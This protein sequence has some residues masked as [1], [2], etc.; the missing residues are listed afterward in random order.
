VDK[1]IVLDNAG[2]SLPMHSPSEVAGA[3]L[4]DWSLVAV[5]ATVIFLG[6]T[7]YYGVCLYPGLGGE[8]NSGD[9]AK[10]QVLGVAPIMMHGPGYPLILMIASGLRALELPI[11]GWWLIT[12]TISAVPGAI[13]NAVAFL[14]IHRLT[15]HF[16]AAIAAA[17]LLGSAS[18]MA[19]QAT[20]AEVYA[21]HI[22]FVLGIIYLLLRFLEARRIEF[23]LAAA[24]VYAFSFGNHLMM[25]MMLPLF[26][27]LTFLH[28]RLILRSDVIITVL[29]FIVLGASQYLYLAYVAWSPHTAWSEY[30]PLQPTAV[31][32]IRYIL[33]FHFSNLYGSGLSSPLTTQALLKTIGNAHPWISG[34]LVAIGLTTLALGWRTRD[35]QWC[36]IALVYGVALCFAPFMLWY[37]APDIQAFH[38]PVLAP[39]LLASIA[40]VMRELHHRPAFWRNGMVVALLITGLFRSGETAVRLSD[41]ES[42]F[43]ELKLAIEKSMAYS[44]VAHPEVALNYPVRMAA[45][46]YEMKGELPKFANYHLAWQLPEK[47]GKRDLIGG[48]LVPH[49]LQAIIGNIEKRRPDMVCQT[50]RLTSLPNY[51]KWPIY[52]YICAAA[53]RRSSL[54][55]AKVEIS[56]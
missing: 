43:A 10:F 20:E 5:T 15:H 9:S 35:S 31:E 27:W 6:S 48:I 41:R 45:M 26:V 33:G 34:P 29:G 55:Q 2:S 49:N 52:S 42:P 39:L 54:R 7:L 24:A 13:A 56:S 46:Y 17:L 12:F 37:G 38:L 11:A 8:L 40:S 28:Q 36:G 25:I 14:I 53:P 47:I 22:A 32:L 18:L 21:L 23:F 44:P 3:R 51:I 16:L 1:T 19:I 30:M 4:K 50:H